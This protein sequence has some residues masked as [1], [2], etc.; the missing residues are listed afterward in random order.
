MSVNEELEE[1]PT[2]INHDPYGDGWLIDL[3]VLNEDETKELM[4]HKEY[5]EFIDKGG[6]DE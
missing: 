1:D 4:D 2:L 5:E 3:E 6:R